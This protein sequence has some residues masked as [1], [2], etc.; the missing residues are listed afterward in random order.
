MDALS[1]AQVHWCGLSMGGM[2]GQWLGA[3]AP[4]R[5]NK[6]ILSNTTSYYANKE[7]WNE[8]I[9]VVREQGL[10][11]V[12]DRLM[13]LWFTQDFRD[14]E[15][16]TIARMKKMLQSHPVDGYVACCAAVRDMDHRQLLPKIGAPTLV[17]AGRHDPATT[18]E[19]AEFIRA[20]IPGAALT[21]L[22]TAHIANVEQPDEYADVVLGFLTQQ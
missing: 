16:A 3:N 2:V 21:V 5:L 20:R 8:R 14:R 18:V 15:K 11:A 7:P 13:A 17:I 4:Q 10:A 6:L 1:L 9:A 22:D 12:A 19:A